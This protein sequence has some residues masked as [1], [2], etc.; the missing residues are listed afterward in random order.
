MLSVSEAVKWLNSIKVKYIHG[1]DEGYDDYR[2][3]ALAMGAEALEASEP[4]VLSKSD[5][6]A[7]FHE[8]LFMEF[9]DDRYVYA[10]FEDVNDRV[11]LCD[12]YSND[13]RSAYIS[14]N[15]V[16]IVDDDC[17]NITWRCW[18][19]MPSPG[20]RKAALWKAGEKE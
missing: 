7:N 20:Q 8:V 2:R 14:Y 13:N 16:I 12:R 15:H 17:Y 11:W 5:V 3:E 18:N 10:V 9:K 4:K 19:I 6:L 1:G